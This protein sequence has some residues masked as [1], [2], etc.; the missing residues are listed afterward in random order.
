MALGALGLVAV[1]RPDVST[2]ASGSRQM[3][4]GLVLRQVAETPTQVLGTIVPLVGVV[5]VGARV[6]GVVMVAFRP[7]RLGVE[8]RP[9]VGP[10]TATDPVCLAGPP[11]RPVVRPDAAIDIPVVLLPLLSD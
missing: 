9:P 1:P 6:A 5:P 8:T 7:P 4:V 10:P 3:Y 11:A 2:V